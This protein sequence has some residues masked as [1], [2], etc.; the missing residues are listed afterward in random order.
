MMM[1]DEDQFGVH[2]IPLGRRYV[3]PLPRRQPG[4]AIEREPVMDT[5]VPPPPPLFTSARSHRQPRPWTRRPIFWVGIAVLLLLGL[6]IGNLGTAAKSVPNP[7]VTPGATSSAPKASPAVE[8]LAPAP[9]SAPAAKPPAEPTK[10]T[11]SGNSVANTPGPLTGGYKVD[12]QFGSWCGI[13]KF[14][15][16]SGNP[17]AGFAEDINEC[18]GDTNAKVSGST[19]VHL[20][21]VSVIKVENTKGKWS[22][23][24]TPLAG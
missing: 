20:T 5:P 22:L 3:D 9:V 19:I 7:P 4:A 13:A 6:C 17:G 21:N 11:G 14:L 1:R 12:Y 15:N 24:F 8:V 23:T 18:A 16:A 2:S 10:V